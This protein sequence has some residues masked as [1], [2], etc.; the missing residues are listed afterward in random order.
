MSA[1]AQSEPVIP[2]VPSH[3]ES[4]LREAVS[5]ITSGYGAKYMLECTEAGE[6]PT[7]LWDAL[8]EKGYCGV[9]LPEE[10][11]GGG[12]GMT[13]L[14]AVQEELALQGC[15]Q[16]L[17]VVSPAIA[18]SILV[19][20]GSREQQEE[21]LPG[22]ARG[23]TRI[24]FAVTEPDAGT[25]TH[26]ITTRAREAADGNWVLKGQK[27]YIS[28]VEHATHILIV[29]RQELDDGE[30]GLPLVFIVDVDAAGLTRE[31]IP[32][33]L[34]LPDK[35]WTLYID[36]IEVSEDRLIGGTT[37]G[38]GTLF[39][40]LNPERIMAAAGSVGAGDRALRQAAEYAREREVWGKPI[41]TH[42]G[43]SHPLAKCKVDLELARLMT[44]KA[45]ALYDAGFKG[46][47]ESSNM[48][49]YAAAEACVE[50]VDQAIQV[51]GGNG[52]AL[53]YGLT[54]MWW[55]ARLNKI[56]PVSREMI[57]NYVAEHS[58]GLPKS[59]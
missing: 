58:L 41:G 21:W 8:A 48:A 42:Q 38:I 9:N 46:A 43:L 44:R 55:G 5:G 52:I 39:D 32:M 57:L 13:G 22:L 50:C 37:G 54:D 34:R 6:P 7:E 16:L 23:T 47:G 25:N 26:N 36:G 10:F 15:T 14:A 19:S 28:G 30:L 4:M 35:Q 53:E 45:C 12:L 3:E 24:A 31:S 18:G 27:T 51:H 29:A 2:L 1:T 59:Y 49:K 33:A 56:A 20:K 17:L 11:G 40:G